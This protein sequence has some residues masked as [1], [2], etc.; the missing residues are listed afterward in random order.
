MK[1]FHIGRQ[2]FDEFKGGDR[3]SLIANTE[4]VVSIQD[5]CHCN[6]RPFPRQMIL[7]HQH[8]NETD[9]TAMPQKCLLSPIENK[10]CSVN[11]YPSYITFVLNDFALDILF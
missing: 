3:L 5:N 11:S 9:D 1:F 10:Y 6:A 2:F 8:P 7:Q 4:M